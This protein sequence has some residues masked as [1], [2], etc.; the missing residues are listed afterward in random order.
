MDNAKRL[1]AYQKQNGTDRLTPA[2]DRRLFHSERKAHTEDVKNG[3]D[4]RYTNYKGKNA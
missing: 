2:Q 4:P 3:K 1:A